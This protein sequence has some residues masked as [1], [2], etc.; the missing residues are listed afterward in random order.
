[1]KNKSFLSSVRCA[2][3][4]LF[5]ALEQEKNFKIYIVHVLLTLP[6]NILLGF[7]Y[8]EFI[9]YGITVVGVFSAECV[10]SAIEKIC[11]FLTQEYDERIK[12]IKDVAAG[13][14][15]WW[16]FA[17]YLSEIIMVAVHLVCG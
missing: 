17:F 11:D 13:A 10:N 2:F 9:I 1:M 4:G 7:S 15:L 16:G 12:M 3:N 6:L 14:V 8:I 5:S